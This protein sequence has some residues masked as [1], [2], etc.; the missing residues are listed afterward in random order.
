VD[1]TTLML[2]DDA[3]RA[4]GKLYIHGGGWDELRTATSPPTVAR[5]ALVITLRVGYE[6]ALADQHLRI[7]LVDEDDRPH[8]AVMV[9]G[10]VR[11]GHPPGLRVGDSIFVSEVV[12]LESLQFE[13]TGSYRFRVFLNDS[14]TP[15]ASLPFRI[16]PLNLPGASRPS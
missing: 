9:S 12:R 11:V 13:K 8:P 10:N 15:D 4:E 5:I 14:Q 3:T 6:E 1:V 7:D 2:A 16:M